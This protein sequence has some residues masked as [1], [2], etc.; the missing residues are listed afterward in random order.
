[1]KYSYEVVIIGGGPAGLAAA[2]HLAFYRRKV[3]VVDRKTGPLWYNLNPIHNYPGITR[4]LSGQSLIKQLQGEVA[5]MG[6]AIL[7]ANALNIDG[8]FPEFNITIQSLSH[9]Q[10]IEIIQTKTILLATGVSILHPRI[11]HQWENWL[12]VTQKAGTCY[13]C[14]DCEAP[15]MVGK[16][17]QILSVGT[18][19]QAISNALALYRFASQ[20]E[21]FIC[22]DGIQPL[23]IEGQKILENSGFVWRAGT[24]QSVS[25]I[26]PGIRQVLTTHEQEKITTNCFFV[27]SIRRPR[28]EL[29]N[30]AGIR[31]NEHDAIITDD[32]GNTNIRGIWAAGDVRPVARQI[33]VAVG[34]G[35]YAALMMNRTLNEL[36]R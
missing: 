21:I 1:M 30:H 24:L 12:T 27:S 14:I 28:S 26:A 8:T 9:T 25:I 22:K 6:A 15:L 36:A 5:S 13:Y 10:K 32:Q 17:V 33:A 18:I 2:K 35:N 11:N 4:P 34:T 3:L 23:D 31:R 29:A 19:N 20:V 7:Q 16:K